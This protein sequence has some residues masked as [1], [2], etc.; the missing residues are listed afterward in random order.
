MKYVLG[1]GTALASSMSF[2]AVAYFNPVDQVITFDEGYDINLTQFADDLI[3][4]SVF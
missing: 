2:G 3:D 4:V 1:T